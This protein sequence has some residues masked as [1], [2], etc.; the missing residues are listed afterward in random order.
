LKIF[1][2]LS[3]VEIGYW[4]LNIDKMQQ[5]RDKMAAGMGQ[6]WGKSGGVNEGQNGIFGV[7][8]YWEIRSY[9]RF[10]MAGLSHFL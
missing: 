6:I 2:P 9:K 3:A 4:I 1:F 7:V 5:D 8:R 10:S